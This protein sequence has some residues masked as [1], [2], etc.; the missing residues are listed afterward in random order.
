MKIENL[1][2]SAYVKFSSKQQFNISCA[3]TPFCQYTYEE[4]IHSKIATAF[5]PGRAKFSWEKCTCRC[6]EET[7]YGPRT[8]LV[9]K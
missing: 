5:A 8:I 3:K 6:Q 1:L 2:K 9:M 7:E 4:N